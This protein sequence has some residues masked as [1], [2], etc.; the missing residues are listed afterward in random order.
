MGAT[1]HV[2]VGNENVGTRMQENG[3]V[4]SAR[5]GRLGVYTPGGL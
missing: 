2:R 3:F 5:P 1:P 4:G